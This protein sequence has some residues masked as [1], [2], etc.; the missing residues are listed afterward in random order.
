MLH[1]YFIIVFNFW[2]NNGNKYNVK[3][4][5]SHVQMYLLSNHVKE[6]HFLFQNSML[7]IVFK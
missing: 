6:K 7:Q 5:V 2:L 4:H 1:S 3:L